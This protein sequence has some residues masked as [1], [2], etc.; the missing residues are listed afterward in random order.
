MKCPKCKKDFEKG[1]KSA[2]KLGLLDGE[3]R[4]KKTIN[5]ILRNNN[6]ILTANQRLTQELLR[7]DLFFPLQDINSIIIPWKKA[8]Q[9]PNHLRKSPL[10]EYI[11]KIIR[12]QLQNFPDLV[13]KSKV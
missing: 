13:D 6:V 8:K 10:R 5:K 2:Y 1:V 3:N 4:L 9:L 7:L 12:E 11:I